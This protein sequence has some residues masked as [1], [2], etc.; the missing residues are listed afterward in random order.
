MIIDFLSFPI[1]SDSEDSIKKMN[2]NILN[3]YIDENLQNNNKISFSLL[4]IEN[5]D[6]FF[7]KNFKFLVS[8]SS[9]KFGFVVLINP[10]NPKTNQIIEIINKFDSIKG[11]AFHPYMHDITNSDIAKIEYIISNIKS[12]AFVGV[13]TA[14]GSKKIYQI[15]PLIIAKEIVKMSKFRNIIFYHAGGS[16]ILDAFLI[17]EMWANVYLE[18]SFSL[19]YWKNSSIENDL[20][21]VIKNLGSHRVIFGSDHPFI[22]IN[23]S[24][25]D[26]DVFFEKYKIDKKMQEDIYFNNAKKILNL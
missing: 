9:N 22:E 21:F 26:H 16:K 6:V 12:D 17:A 10:S 25:K 3:N 15:N 24:L 8:E 11:I 14:Y 4:C 5:D 1:Q 7:D 18:T 23:K 20:N 13:F 2:F 19:S